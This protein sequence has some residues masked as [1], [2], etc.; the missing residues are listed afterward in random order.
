MEKLKVIKERLV[1][2][3]EGEMSKD[4][5]CVNTEELG[6]VIDMIKDLEE[7]MYYCSVTKAMEESKEEKELYEKIQSKMSANY[8]PHAIPMQDN[9][10]MY[11][12]MDREY[13]RMYYSDGGR[14]GNNSSYGNGRNS[15]NSNSGG[16]RSGMSGMSR[17]GDGQRSSGGY[18]SEIRDSREG[19][20]PM[21]RRSYMEMKELHKG[22]PAQMKELENYMQ[23]LSQDILEMVEDASPEEK[24]MLQQKIS[25]LASKIK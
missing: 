11:R 17:G 1:S 25:T 14:G 5:S 10:D 3:V 16:G 19:R 24:A 22:V 15:G 12:D 20:S 21:T 18:P 6:E 9:S 7:A 13:G 23:E 2:C 4:L 8:M